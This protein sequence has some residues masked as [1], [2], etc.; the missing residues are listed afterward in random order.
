MNKEDIDAFV[1][2]R[3][4]T[5]DL[6]LLICG[7]RI[8]KGSSRLVFE[9]AYDPSLVVKV[10]LQAKSFQNVNEWVIWNNIKDFAP[11]AKWFAPCVA[12]SECGT[13][14]IQKKV[15]FL[16][17]EKFPKKVPEFLTDR[18]YENYGLY[19]GRIVCC[20]YG[21]VVH[22]LETKLQKAKWWSENDI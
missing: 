1:E 18:K 12:I 20:D 7:D 15:E 9:C 6:F 19:N 5:T 10:E 11:V 2:S 13:V 21:L 16:H 4:I 22:T 14:L 17:K 8:G 3:T